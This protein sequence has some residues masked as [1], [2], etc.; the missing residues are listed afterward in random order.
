MRWLLTV[1][2]A[3]LAGPAWAGENEAEK[4]FRQMEKTVRAAKTLQVQFEAKIHI[5]GQ[6]GTIKG[7][8]VLAEDD[9]VAIKAD[10]HF[11]GKD[12]AFVLVSDGSKLYVKQSTNPLTEVKEMPKD[13][14]LYLRAA[15][16]R[17]GTFAGVEEIVRGKDAPNVDEVFR[18]SDFKLGTREKGKD[19]ET[20][21][22]TYN[23]ALKT[24]DR[25]NVKVWIETRSHLPVKLE[26]R[27]EAAGFGVEVSE[28]YSEY[29]VDGKIDAKLFEPLK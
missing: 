7:S 10:V 26:I 2:A 13:L 20:Q 8:A 22:V 23:V 24:K 9:R 1:V 21:I 4:L 17:V 18:V 16:A 19:T 28:T 15:W 12:G 5:K 6:E 29:L 25:A 11:E 14:G 3:L 27:V